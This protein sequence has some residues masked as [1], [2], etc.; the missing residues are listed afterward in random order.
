[1]YL[2]Y[3]FLDMNSYFA[4]VEQQIHPELRNKPIAV[5]PVAVDSSCCIAASYEAKKFGIK[6]GTP[7]AEAKRLCPEIKIVEATPKVY[8]QYHHEIIKTV[9]SCLHVEDVLSIDEMIGRLSPSER[10]PEKATTLGIKV[11][12]KIK[13]DVGECLKCSVGISTNR[14][15]AKIAAEKQ[16]PDGLTIIQPQDLPHTMYELELIDIPGIGSRMEA[17]LKKYGVNTVYRMYQLSEEEL[18]SIWG[19]VLGNEWWYHLRGYDLPK[20]ETHRGSFGQ[21]HVLPPEFRS[22]E[23]ARAVLLRLIHKAAVRLRAKNYWAKTLM[24]SIRYL[25]GEKWRDFASLGCSQ[26][27]LTMVETAIRLLEIKKQIK[28]KP[29]KVAIV[30]FNLLEEK[31]VCLPIFQ[32]LLAQEKL[33]H[34]M[35][36]INA[37]YGIHTV[38]LGCIH[39]VLHTAPMRIAFTNIPEI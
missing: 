13:K 16:K 1:M 39:N 22:E 25:N 29:I 28:A 12:E 26:D 17:R 20:K 9:E 36:H 24:V 8:V 32:K 14:F 4:S 15:L 10:N 18:R 23:G 33:S 2:N 7:I 21:S 31:S 30:L 34:A 38:Y 5:A 11:K 35:D 27:T 6:T 19:S 37:K 3:L